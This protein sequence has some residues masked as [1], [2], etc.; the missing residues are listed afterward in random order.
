M[1]FLQHGT[2]LESPPLLRIW[3]SRRARGSL[4]VRSMELRSGI[5]SF[6]LLAAMGYIS[7]YALFLE[8]RKSVLQSGVVAYLAQS[9]RA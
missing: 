1:P 6:L 2:Q 4:V 3:G 9:T 5:D 8:V 7:I